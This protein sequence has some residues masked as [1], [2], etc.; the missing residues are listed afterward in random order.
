MPAAP[1]QPAAVL[2]PSEG[3]DGGAASS[4]AGGGGGTPGAAARL[5]LSPVLDGSLAESQTDASGP[6][7]TTPCGS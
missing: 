3:R 4:T 7:V 1:V 2:A 6:P 5:A